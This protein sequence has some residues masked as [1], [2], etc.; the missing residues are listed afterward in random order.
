[1]VKCRNASSKTTLIDLL[2][3]KRHGIHRIKIK[4]NYVEKKVNLKILWQTKGSFVTKIGWII[5]NWSVIKE[6]KRQIKI[7]WG[8]QAVQKRYY[9]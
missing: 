1:M 2:G 5:R 6:K 8:A 3:L 4:R 7:D 9:V